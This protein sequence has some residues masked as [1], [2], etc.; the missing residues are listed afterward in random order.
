M[1]DYPTHLSAVKSL[2]IRI[3]WD[4]EKAQVTKW[5]PAPYFLLIHYPLIVSNVGAVFARSLRS[6]AALRISYCSSNAKNWLDT[7]EK[8]SFAAKTSG[9]ESAYPCST[10]RPIAILAN[11]TC[12]P[13]KAKSAA[14][15][16]SSSDCS[17]LCIPHSLSTYSLMFSFYLRLTNIADNI[18]RNSTIE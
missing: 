6:R 15:D 7:F 16:I 13:I 18:F 9:D 4:A 12:S 17:M 1:I 10:R 8:N 2:P 11:S 5:L 3:P 14:S